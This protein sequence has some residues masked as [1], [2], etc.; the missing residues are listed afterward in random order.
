MLPTRTFLSVDP[1]DE[2][3]EWVYRAIHDCV[4]PVWSWAI[5]VGGVR[6]PDTSIVAPVHEGM[7]MLVMASYAVMVVAGGLI[8]MTHETLQTRYSVKEILPRLVLGLGLV[9][10][11]LLILEGATGVVDD[12]VSALIDL[13]DGELDHTAFG[14]EGPSSLLIAMYELSALSGLSKMSLMALLSAVLLLAGALVL[15]VSAFMRWLAMLAVVA[16]APLA[17]ACHG[18]PVTEGA[19]RLW[20]R[21]LAACMAS[22]IGQAGCL[23]LWRYIAWDATGQP[24]GELDYYKSGGTDGYFLGVVYMLITVWAMWKVHTSAFQWARGRPV[25]IPGARMVAGMVAWRAMDKLGVG[26][27]RRQA[28]NAGPRSRPQLAGAK[29]DLSRFRL[30]AGWK[31]P[32]GGDRAIR[33]RRPQVDMEGVRRAKA[34]AGRPAKPQRF[35]RSTPEPLV[36]DAATPA[37]ARRTGARSRRPGAAP[38]RTVPPGTTRRRTVFTNERFGTTAPPSHPLPALPPDPKRFARAQR[39]IHPTRRPRK[40]KDG[41]QS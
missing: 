19:A 3:M 30:S 15:L 13:D 36:V 5:D 10:A 28:K 39:E 7:T 24:R 2:L 38:V 34:K 14:T 11:S 25:R 21:M 35:Q 33:V 37:G 26:R 4:E 16:L 9:W 31:G 20:W 17:L 40:T 23:F 18:L 32:N 41:D 29:P 1:M 12:V 27:K 8:A 6:A 22:S